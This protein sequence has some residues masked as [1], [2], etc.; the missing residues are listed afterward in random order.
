MLERV[1]ASSK[2]ELTNKLIERE[3]YYIPSMILITMVLMAI[4]G[5]LAI[6]EWFSM[7]LDANRMEIIV[8]A[9]LINLRR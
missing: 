9:N 7:M 6:R 8:E 3:S 5:E 2:E 1:T 4:L